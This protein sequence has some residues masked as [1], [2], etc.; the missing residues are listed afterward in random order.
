MAVFSNKEGKLTMLNTVSVS[1][2][3]DIQRLVEENLQ[4]V[5]D[6]HFIATEYR[7][8]SGRIDTLALDSDGSP[9]IIE[10]KRK[11][12]DNVIN[13][14]LSYLKWLK[15]QRPEFFQMLMLNK[16][17]KDTSDSIRIDWKNPRI[18]CVAE[19]FSQYDIDTVEMVQLRIELFKYRQYEQNLFTLEMVTVNEQ[20]NRMEVYQNV[21]VESNLAIIHTMKEQA[22]AS[23]TTRAMFDE[24]RER[25]MGMDDF[26]VEKPGKRTIAYRL[27]KN[28]AEILIKKDRLII[29]LRQ[30]DYDDPRKL[31]EQIHEGYS[32]PLSSRIALSDLADVGYVAAIVEQSFQ[33]IL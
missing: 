30:V 1:K 19:S 15:A 5:L 8:S 21:P 13:Q 14:A 10:F 22:G 33:S 3:K 23:H 6:L 2:E 16:L 12:D 20:K 28:F 27:T 9:V 18:I 26:L 7:T 25:I 4:E 29:D 17:G 24:L 32:T 11:R 31:I